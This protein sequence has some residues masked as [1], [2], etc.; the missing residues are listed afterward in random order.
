MGDYHG[1]V[2][3]VKAR[4]GWNAINAVKMTA[5]IIDE[6]VFNQAGVRIADQVQAVAEESLYPNL[7]NSKV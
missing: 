5:Y 3:D 2:D 1:S 4:P 7:F 6:D